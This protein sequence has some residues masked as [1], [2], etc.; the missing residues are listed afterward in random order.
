MKQALIAALA[1]ILVVTLSCQ[2][3][4]TTPS[5]S[6]H[7]QKPDTIDTAESG[8]LSIIDDKGQPIVNAYALIG[9]QASTENSWLASDKN[10]QIV[11]P[12]TWTTP[13]DL[14]VEAT[15]H[16]RITLKDQEP[17]GRT[18]T[19]KKKSLF[20]RLNM[21]GTVHGITTKDKDG[22]IDFAILLESMTKTD[23]LNFNIN[24][25]VSP[26]TEKISVA[27]FEFPVPQNLFIPKQKENYLFLTVTLQKP[28]FNLSY[29]SY[30]VKSVYS[31]QGKFPMKKVMTELQNKKPYYELVNHFDFSS[32][33]RITHNFVANAA[34]PIVDTMQVKLNNTYTMKAPKI[35]AGQVLLGLSGFK[36]KN[37]Y[38]PL[39]VKYMQ[40]EQTVAFK[41]FSG[42]SPYFIGV[43]KNEN[44]F[45]ADNADSE[46][47]SISMNTPTT[48]VQSLPLIR[49]PS[50]INDKELGIDIPI[51]SSTEYS[52]QGMLVVISEMQDI[53]MDD[54]KTVRFKIPV[55]EIHAPS[56][57]SQLVIPDI[58]TS[59]SPKRVEV[60][61][62]AKSIDN[63]GQQNAVTVVSTHEDR[64]EKSTHLTK[65]ASDY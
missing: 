19:L 61:L 24:K 59:T 30:G 3:S 38:Q 48:A 47:M 12:K 34:E 42:V 33:G 4:P 46:R 13:Q 55:W 40:S 9:K 41:T 65:S 10:G 35:A 50:W 60:T 6:P 29:D 5:P 20:P 11:L 14:T 58:N 16:V 43:V 63:S 28:W 2:K 36:E 21:K 62:L 45:S 27:G 17:F 32:A 51:I 7:L 49:N 8:T 26:W 39:D 37:F 56:W 18:I 57:S 1:V 22:F 53:K 25:V 15:D 31:L 54:G 64:I 52:E 23:I 44:E